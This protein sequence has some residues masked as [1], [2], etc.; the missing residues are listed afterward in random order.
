[1]SWERSLD[2]S[3]SLLTFLDTTSEARLIRPSNAEAAVKNWGLVLLRVACRV[4]R[5]VSTPCAY[6]RVSGPRSPS[7][8][9]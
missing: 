2:V 9:C 6:A 7:L 1:M 8:Q 3:S 5:V 4:S